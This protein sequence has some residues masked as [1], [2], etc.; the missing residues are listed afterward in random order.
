MA[1]VSIALGAFFF[2]SLTPKREH[3]FKGAC[4]VVLEELWMVPRFEA[5]PCVFLEAV[6]LPGVPPEGCPR[7]REMNQ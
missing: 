3:D 4:L 5:F 1:N 6:G 2:G 7:N